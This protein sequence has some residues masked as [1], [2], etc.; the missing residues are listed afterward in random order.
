MASRKEY[1]V[2]FTARGLSDAWDSTNT[3]PG[4][5]KS[6]Q[7]L[8]FDQANPELISARPGVGAALT[9][10][11]GFS[12]PTSISVHAVVAGVVYGMV[13]TN[14]TAGKDEPFA[15]NLTSNTFITI[16]GV[17]AGNV[18]NSLPISGNVVPPTMAVIGPKIIIT[19][20]GFSGVGS[21]FFGVIDITTPATP[22]WS[23]ANTT[24]HLLP[25]VP[26]SV[27]NFN[28]RAYFS[29]SNTAWYSDVLAPTVMTNAGQ[30]L[31]IGDTDI[32]TSLT[33]LPIQTSSAGVVASL[34]VFKSLQIWQILGDAA[35]TGSLSLNF[36]AL[37]IGC[38]APRSIVQTPIGTIFAGIDGPYYISAL[39]QVLPLTKDQNKSVQDL[40]RP[41]QSINNPGRAAAAFTG[42]IYRICLD[43]TIDGVAATNDYWF[44]ADVR[45]WNGPH[46]FP[47]DCISQMGSYFVLSHRSLGAALF[48]SSYLPSASSVYTDNG[49]AYSVNF[50]T[51]FFP[52]SQ[53]I[54]VK[55]I[56]ES[57]IELSSVNSLLSYFVTAYD[58]R[59]NI[60]SSASVGLVGNSLLWGGGTVWGSGPVWSNSVN[61]GL[62]FTIPWPAPLVF[63]KIAISVTAVPSAALSIGT[64][65]F[66]YIDCGYTN[67]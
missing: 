12:S 26:T 48:A 49:A 20:A 4:A 29:C 7:N 24:V 27:C 34:I 64:S 44:D 15:Y 6:L 37:N 45:R 35:V 9:N 14:R 23:A 50:Q 57:T 33:G 62:T 31:T 19:H 2:R 21:N 5:C 60:L 55:Q 10:F 61:K 13:A 51:A 8:I 3:F 56:V 52:K 25:S 63:K 18:P 65:Y 22:A 38:I 43:S 46:T 36:L 58:E 66:K 16:S 17:T 59:F 39:G 67:L 30:S 47:Y 40:Q 42:S 53:N 28:N 32:I 1:P 54:N 11:A 41:F